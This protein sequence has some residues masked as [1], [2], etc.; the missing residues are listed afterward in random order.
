MLLVS[1]IA[2]MQLRAACG[3]M[4]LVQNVSARQGVLVWW[5]MLVIGCTV[6]A[7]GEPCDSNLCKP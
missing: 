5:V 6:E 2:A 4:S 3:T 1:V 7:K